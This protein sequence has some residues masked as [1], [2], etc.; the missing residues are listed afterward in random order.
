LYY[1]C[2]IS[3][4]EQ[5]EHRRLATFHFLHKHSQARASKQITTIKMQTVKALLLSLFYRDRN[6]TTQ[7][8]VISSSHPQVPSGPV[9]LFDLLAASCYETG[10]H[11]TLI[12]VNRTQAFLFWVSEALEKSTWNLEDGAEHAKQFFEQQKLPSTT[13]LYTTEHLIGDKK[14][15]K[16][17]M[18]SILNLQSEAALSVIIPFHDRHALEESCTT[19]EAAFGRRS[20]FLKRYLWLAAVSIL[21][22]L[23]A[24]MAATLFTARQHS[25]SRD[26]WIY[27]DVKN[28]TG[29]DQLQF[30]YP[31]PNFT[32]WAAETNHDTDNWFVRLDD[33]A[34]IPPHLVDDDER[35]YQDW[36]GK[37]YPVYKAIGD[38][39]DYL[40]ETF[41]KHAMH[42]HTKLEID[43]G[44]HI[45]HCILAMKRY[46]KAMESG[47]HVCPR[48]VNHGHIGHC[49]VVLEQL[50]IVDFPSI[51]TMSEQVI[52]T[53]NSW[54][55]SA[56]F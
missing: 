12:Q 37:H 22:I 19:T 36:F 25:T 28:T 7:L 15:A 5:H 52:G 8:R 43:H 11:K 26:L 55:V 21:L 4:L 41:W 13:F 44:F 47:M 42:A 35:R 29:L 53:Q 20:D 27:W 1:R 2:V 40:N 46:W 54:I 32:T 10:G 34:L 50:V 48:D 9:D 33:Q 38:S 49:F 3:S 39:K 14:I 51:G 18:I 17:Y 30:T 16:T 31:H 24:A 6:A 45:A 23:A 56:C